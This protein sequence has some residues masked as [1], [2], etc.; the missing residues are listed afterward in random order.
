[1]TKATRVVV[2]QVNPI[3]DAYNATEKWVKDHKDLLIEV[4]AI[5]GGVL[6]GLACTAV[7]A[8]AGAVACMVGAAALIDLAK[9]SA[10]DNTHNWGDAF[11]SLGTGAL[12]GL[13]GGVGGIVGGKV[14]AFAA[15]K[16]GGLA[17]TLAGRTSPG[18]VEGRPARQRDRSQGAATG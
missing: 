2:Q 8:G 15:G 16:L 5:A 18:A 9:D 6:A 13:A 10:Q 4:A 3:K 17:G 1:M 12:Q 11:G 7:T 14:A